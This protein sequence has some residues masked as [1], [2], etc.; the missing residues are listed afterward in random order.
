MP[1]QALDERIV[2]VSI[3]VNGQIKTYSSPLAIVVNGTKYANALQNEAEITLT[4]LDRAT[5][6]YILTETSPYNA[7]RTAKSVTVEAGR[8]SYGTAVIYRGNIVTASVSQPPDIG[9]TLK[10]LTGN[11]VKGSVI[12]RS[13]PG[14]ATLYQIS[15]GIAQDQDTLLNFQATDKNIGNYQFAGAATNQVALL[16]SFGGIN[17]F[18]D[19]NVLYVKDSMVPLTGVLRIL[20]ADTG[21][22]GIPEFTEWGLKVKF[23]IDNRTTLGGALQ[24][25]SRQYP[26]INGTYV[27]YKLGFQIASRDIPFYYIAEAAR[28]SN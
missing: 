13:Q 24:V 3:E 1:V 8:V 20:N 4:N 26:A 2:K 12:S 22:I 10:C 11:F 14:L 17:A 6:D 27:I 15:A 23:L 28:V 16:N 5:Q 25:T 7:N 21:M 19:D 18:V 9:V